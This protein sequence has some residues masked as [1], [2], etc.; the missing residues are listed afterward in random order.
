[1]SDSDLRRL[2]ALVR[3]ALPTYHGSGRAIEEALAIG[4]GNLSH[5]LDGRLELRVRHLLA[6]AKMLGVPPHQ[7]LELGC[8]EATEAASRDLTDFVSMSLPP[9]RKVAVQAAKAVELD[10]RIRK[11]VH[12]ELEARFGAAQVTE[13]GGP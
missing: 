1:M 4:H 2:R 8:P 12:E 5:L 13:P 3:E 11:I 7:F 9:E 10:N 6:I